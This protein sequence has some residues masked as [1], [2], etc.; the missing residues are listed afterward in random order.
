MNGARSILDLIGSTPVVRL[1]NLPGKDDAEVWG[2][3]ESSNPGGSVK[4]RICLS[5]IEA[6]EREQKLKPGATIVEPTSGNTGIGLALVAAVK[7]YRLILTMPDTMS[8][9]RRSLLTAYGARLIL[10]P[11]TKGMGGA[12][13]KA[14]ELLLEHSDYFM[15]QQFNNPAN[16][17]IHRRTTAVELLSQFK[18]IDAFVAGVGTGGTITGVGEIL[19]EKMKGI[20]IY[21]VEPAASPVISGGEP[22]YHKIQGIGAGFIPAVLNTQVY[23]EVVA[24]SDEDAAHYT[25]RLALEE[26]ILVGISSGAACS[27]ALKVARNLGKGHVVVTIFADRGEHYFSTDL[28]DDRQWMQSSKD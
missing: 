15:P 5:M 25:R 18:R 8:E 26:G 21:A 20:R 13:R 16:P 7:G 17:E 1:R 14:E 3:L 28:F 22:G 11:D 12:I 23:D 27:A 10:T 19:K 6:A 4:D 9:E 24:V 2:K